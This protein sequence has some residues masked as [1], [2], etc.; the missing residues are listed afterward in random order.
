MLKM[1]FKLPSVEYIGKMNEFLINKKCED[2]RL[3]KL[4]SVLS[5]FCYYSTKEEMISSIVLSIIKDHHFIDGNK[6]TALAMYLLL[7][8]LNNIDHINKSDELVDVV[9]NI[10]ENHYSVEECCSILFKK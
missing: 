3:N 2:F 7:C 1:I 9:V 10:A 6:R 5:S 4:Q 8:R